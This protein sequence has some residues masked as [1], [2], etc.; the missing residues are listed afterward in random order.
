MQVVKPF[1]KSGLCEVIKISRICMI[2]HSCTV[3]LA[4]DPGTS[5]LTQRS[6]LYLKDGIATKWYQSIV[7]PVGSRPK[8]GLELGKDP[9]IKILL[10]FNLLKRKLLILILSHILLSLI[11]RLKVFPYL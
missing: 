7:L 10:I 11:H 2:F 4:F 3:V 5:T 9:R 6:C 1:C 8:Y